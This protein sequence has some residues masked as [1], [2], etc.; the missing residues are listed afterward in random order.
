MLY[1][2]ELR[3]HILVLLQIKMVG[4]ER[5]ELP[6]SCSQS[7]RATRL[8]YTPIFLCYYRQAIQHRPCEPP[9]NTCYICRGQIKTR[10]TASQQNNSNRGTAKAVTDAGKVTERIRPDKDVDG[11]HPYNIG[12]LAL[13]RPS[14]RSC[15]PY[16]TEELHPWTGLAGRDYLRRHVVPEA[17]SSITIP[18][19][20]SSSR[21]RS[22][23]AQFFSFLAVMRLS[24][25]DSMSFSDGP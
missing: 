8:R 21:I 16:A 9:D 11:F 3:A 18:A 25:S 24:I 23:S 10:S 20:S 5:F 19:A 1:P 6:T 7:R 15:T 14:L 2:A 17:P 13:R 12:R 4:V 22:A